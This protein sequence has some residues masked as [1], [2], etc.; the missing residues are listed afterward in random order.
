M[1]HAEQLVE[2]LAPVTIAALPA[3]HAAQLDAPA[4][5]T[6]EPEGQLVHD[7]VAELAEYLPTAQFEHALLDAATEYVPAEQTAQAE[8]A[9]P[10]E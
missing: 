4:E 10:E 6:Y 8:A 9:S 5:F 1:E 3:T 2:A 7:I